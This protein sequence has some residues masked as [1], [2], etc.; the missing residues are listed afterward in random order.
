MADTSSGNN[1]S[2]G[3]LFTQDAILPGI[4]KERHL[5]AGAGAKQGD[6]VYSNNFGGFINLVIGNTGQVLMVIGGVPTWQTYPQTGLVANLPSS[7]R[8]AGDMYLATNG[9][10]IYFWTGSAWKSAALT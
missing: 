8:F 6:L 4:I 10:T 2:F 3:V 5:V 1:K 9:P 7:G